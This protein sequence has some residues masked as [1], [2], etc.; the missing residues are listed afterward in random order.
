M[1]T[2]SVMHHPLLVCLQQQLLLIAQ[3]QSLHNAQNLLRMCKGF[4]IMLGK[5]VALFA[6]AAA[7]T[8]YTGEQCYLYFH[9]VVASPQCAQLS[10]PPFLGTVADLYTQ[11]IC[12]YQ[13]K[14]P[15]ISAAKAPDPNSDPLNLSCAEHQLHSLLQ[16]TAV[17]DTKTIEQQNSHHNQFEEWRS[18]LD[19]LSTSPFMMAILLPLFISCSRG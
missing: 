3:S 1:N 9:V 4:H 5:S 11:C 6:Q 7:A 18:M 8:D 14:P 10:L 13:C 16:G 15:H 2:S 12:D 17:E 19:T